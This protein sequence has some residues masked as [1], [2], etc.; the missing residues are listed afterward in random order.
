MQDALRSEFTG[1]LVATA[2]PSTPELPRHV[3]RALDDLS[4]ARVLRLFK[5][6]LDAELPLLDLACRPEHMLITC[7]ADAA[8][9]HTRDVAVCSVAALPPL[10]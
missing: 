4:P 1:K 6:V 7:A 2:A 8:C 9:R 5:R 10:M 3:D